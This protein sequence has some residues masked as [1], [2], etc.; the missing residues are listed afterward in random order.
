MKSTITKKEEICLK[1]AERYKKNWEYYILVADAFS[2]GQTSM[3]DEI[4]A[5]LQEEAHLLSQAGC[6]AASDYMQHSIYLAQ[7]T[8]QEKVEQELNNGEHQIGAKSTDGI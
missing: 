4:T 5:N 2:A 6:G 3:R 8:G 7:N 1:Y